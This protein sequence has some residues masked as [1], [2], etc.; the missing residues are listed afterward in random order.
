MHNTVDCCFHESAKVFTQLFEET[1]SQSAFSELLR[2]IPVCRAKCVDVYG[3]SVQSVNITPFTLH[4]FLSLLSN[5]AARECF[6]V[7][8]ICQLFFSQSTLPVCLT[9]LIEVATLSN[10]DYSQDL[11]HEQTHSQH[12]EERYDNQRT[13]SGSRHFK[14]LITIR[15][16]RTSA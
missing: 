13:S 9:T 12:S 11:V 3:M 5:P 2:V 15:H 16:W 1:I 14:M 7:V 6:P 10:H 4:R 8:Q